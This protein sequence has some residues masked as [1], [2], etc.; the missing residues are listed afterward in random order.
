VRLDE[1]EDQDQVRIYPMD[2][3][4]H[5]LTSVNAT[6]QVVIDNA[7]NTV[8]RAGRVRRSQA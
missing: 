7:Q 1:D 3:L 4:L 8:Q 2:R 5:R 6:V